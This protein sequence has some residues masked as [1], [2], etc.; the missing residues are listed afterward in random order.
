MIL[1]QFHPDLKWGFGGLKLV[2][3]KKADKGCLQVKDLVRKCLFLPGSSAEFPLSCAGWE[4]D[5]NCI[6]EGLHFLQQRSRRHSFG[7]SGRREP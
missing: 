5:L 6:S 1:L 4:R 7:H 3:I 2:D